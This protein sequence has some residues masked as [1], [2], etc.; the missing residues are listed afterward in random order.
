MVWV[1]SSKTPYNC[2]ANLWWYIFMVNE[3]SINYETDRQRHYK[4]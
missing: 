3:K 2:V 1:K 4:A